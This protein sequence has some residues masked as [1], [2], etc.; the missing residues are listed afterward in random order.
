MNKDFNYLT[1]E[2]TK[3]LFTAITDKRDRAELSL[4]NGNAVKALEDL[5]ALAVVR[6]V[7]K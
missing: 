2:E 3:Q 1:Q 6:L 5:Q 7:Y 4:S